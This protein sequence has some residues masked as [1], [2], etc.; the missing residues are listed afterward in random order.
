[1]WGVAL[2]HGYL[3]MGSWPRILEMIYWPIVN[4]MMIGCLSLYVVRQFTDAQ[5][6]ASTFIAGALLGEFLVRV[7]FAMLVLFMEE[8]WSRNLGHLFASPIRIADYVSSLFFLSTIRCAL[9]LTPTIFAAKYLFHFSLFSLGWPLLAYIGL[10]VLNGWW[11]GMLIQ[12]LLLRFGVVAE[13][14]GWMGIWLLIPF[15][16]PYYP[17]SVL[18]PWIQPISHALPS[19]YVFESMKGLLDHSGWHP[20]KLLLA[21]GLNILYFIAAAVTFR[22]AYRSTLRRGGLLQTGE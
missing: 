1:M 14:I 17:V 8:I 3:L 19:T 18:P 16:A 11:S 13:W 20:E 6:L 5:V 21:L 9:A 7:N 15:S 22:S 12:S 2:R 4:I 10:L